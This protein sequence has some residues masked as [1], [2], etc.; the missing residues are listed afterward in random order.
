MMF[1]CYMLPAICLICAAV[2]ASTHLHLADQSCS[3]SPQHHLDNR[4]RKAK[5]F[6]DQDTT[7]PTELELQATKHYNLASL[8]PFTTTE[9]G[10][11]KAP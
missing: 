4:Q 8:S 10:E 3:C 6:T 1:T 9:L 11:S 7:T 2:I 5:A